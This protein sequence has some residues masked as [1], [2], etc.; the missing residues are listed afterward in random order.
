MDALARSIKEQLSHKRAHV[1]VEVSL[2]SDSHFYTGLSENLSEGGVFVATHA[3][4]AVGDTI[5]LTLSVPDSKPIEVVGKVRWL[6]DVSDR[7]DLPTGMG[8]RFISLSEEDARAIRRFLEKR[9]PLFFD[10]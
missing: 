5:E 8:L 1:H 2:V 4:R 7:I 10:D 6:R 9:A 3:L